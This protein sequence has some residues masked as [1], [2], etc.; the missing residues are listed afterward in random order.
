MTAANR[1][2]SVPKELHLDYIVAAAN[3]KAF[4]CGLAPFTDRAAIKDM[5]SKV[6]VPEFV[7][8]SG[9][10]IDVTDAEAQA[11]SNNDS[12]GKWK[13]ELFSPSVQYPSIWKRLPCLFRC[14]LVVN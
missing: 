3:L 2:V 13:E 1:V 7:P 5:V 11:R 10:K 14:S 12:F 8:K 9:I 6:K 4:M